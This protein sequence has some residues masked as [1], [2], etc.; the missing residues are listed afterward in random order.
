MDFPN[1]WVHFPNGRVCLPKGNGT[2]REKGVERLKG[3]GREMKRWGGYLTGC[4]K[5]GT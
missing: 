1:G 4:E 3:E 5:V 2:G